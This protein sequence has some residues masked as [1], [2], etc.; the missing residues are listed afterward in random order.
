MLPPENFFLPSVTDPQAGGLAG[1]G[2]CQ[3]DKQ[4]RANLQHFETPIGEQDNCAKPHH[5]SV[6]AAGPLGAC[7]ESLLRPDFGRKGG[8]DVPFLECSVM[9]SLVPI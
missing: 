9:S 2:W 6:R 8:W 1:A 4:S 5:S 7:S 3:G